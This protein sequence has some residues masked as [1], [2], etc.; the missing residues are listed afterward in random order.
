MCVSFIFRMSEIWDHPRSVFRI[1]DSYILCATR[2]DLV[3]NVN[4]TRIAVSQ[5]SL[6]KIGHNHQLYINIMS[7]EQA[8]N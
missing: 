2:D 4:L 8:S 6:V 1:S 5:S 3:L 7:S